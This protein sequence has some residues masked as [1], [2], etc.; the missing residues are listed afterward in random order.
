LVDLADEDLARRQFPVLAGFDTPRELDRFR[1]P[2]ETRAA[3]L[4]TEGMDGPVPA[5]RLE[6]MPGPFPGVSLMYFPRDWRGWKELVLECT[7]P[8][9]APLRLTVRIDDLEHDHHFD[10]RFNRSFDVNPGRREI[11]VPLADVEAAPAGRILDLG[12]VRSVVLFV[13]RLQAERAL[14][15]NRLRLDR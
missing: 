1:W 13:N 11:R 3:I 14:L 10:D 2:P 4:A 7:N 5:L 12:R 8:G 6:L 15:V 9:D